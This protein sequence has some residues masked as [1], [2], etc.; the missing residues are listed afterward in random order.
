MQR[1]FA[2]FDAGWFPNTD[3]ASK[4]EVREWCAKLKIPIK[5]IRDEERGW[6]VSWPL[7]PVVAGSLQTEVV[8][9][10]WKRGGNFFGLGEVTDKL[11]VVG[12]LLTVAERDQDNGGPGK[13]PEKGISQAGDSGGDIDE[14]LWYADKMGFGMPEPW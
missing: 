6:S 2:L 7:E 11:K 4:S 8:P 10:A 13:K 1:W 12:D 9:M 14:M 5:T 3:W